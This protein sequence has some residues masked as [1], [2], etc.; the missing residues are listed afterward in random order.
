MIVVRSDRV[1]RDEVPVRSVAS[2]HIVG[3]GAARNAFDLGDTGRAYRPTNGTILLEDPV[4]DV[5]VV[6]ERR[7]PTEHEAARRAAVE[8]V[9]FAVAPQEIAGLSARTDTPRPDVAAACRGCR[10]RRRRCTTRCQG[11]LCRAASASSQDPSSVQLA[12]VEE[13][14]VIPRLAGDPCP[15]RTSPRRNP[16]TTPSG[17]SSRPCTGLLK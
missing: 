8:E 17:A 9:V 10:R 12:A 3:T 11:S 14:A 13:R 2:L 16:G 6:A 1:F 15:G 5:V 7:R 4:E